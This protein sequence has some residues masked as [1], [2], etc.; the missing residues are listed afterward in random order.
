MDEGYTRGVAFILEGATEKVFYKAFLN[1]M[2]EQKNAA[3]SKTRNTNDICYEWRA[4]DERI[5]V[6]FDV[7]GTVTQMTNSGLWFSNNCAK[8]YK[9]PWI[10][11]L[12]YDTDSYEDSVTKFYEDD[13]DVLRNDLISSKAEEIIDLAACADIED[14]LLCDVDGVCS[15]LAID[16]PENLKGRKGKSKMKNLY[17]SCGNTYHEG[18]KA[19][20]MIESL[21]LQ[22]IVDKSPLDLKRLVNSF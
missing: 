7:V 18:D 20:T 11:F 5:I 2:A 21:D 9:I 6:Q 16:K 8:E 12:C 4:A 19:E 10:V 13:W 14:I 17:R 3:F 22:K 15:F 1:W